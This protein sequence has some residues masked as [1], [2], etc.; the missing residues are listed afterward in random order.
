MV[1]DY[2]HES[3]ESYM[4]LNFMFD[5]LFLENVLEDIRGSIKEMTFF[6][7]TNKRDTSDFVIAGL[8]YISTPIFNV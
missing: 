6:F 7:F 2:L 3:L 8:T 5:T 4:F 1:I